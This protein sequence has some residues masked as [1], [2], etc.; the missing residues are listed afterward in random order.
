MGRECIGLVDMKDFYPGKDHLGTRAVEALC[1]RI[2][3]V[4]KG[5]ADLQNVYS[6]AL[7]LCTLLLGTVEKCK[8]YFIWPYEGK[9][10]FINQFY[11]VH[12]F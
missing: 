12:N 1:L 4:A 3:H 8:I 6:P 11:S 5:I 9:Q 10:F 2:G 7:K